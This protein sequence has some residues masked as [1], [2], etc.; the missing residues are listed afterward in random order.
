[1]RQQQESLSSVADGQSQSLQLTTSD[2]TED[3]EDSDAAAAALRDEL[4]EQRD[5]VD[6]VSEVSDTRSTAADTESAA[7][8]AASAALSPASDV[9]VSSAT[10]SQQSRSS[11]SKSNCDSTFVSEAQQEISLAASENVLSASMDRLPTAAA[12]CDLVVPLPSKAFDSSSSSSALTVVNAAATAELVQN[13][14]VADGTELVTHGTELVAHGTELAARGTEPIPVTQTACDT[15]LVVHG[16]QVVN[17]T[18]T[19]CGTEPVAYG[20]QVADG[21][22]AVFSSTGPVSTTQTSRGTEP[23]AHGTVPVPPTR[24]TRG[25]ELNACGT[26][27]DQ[28]K[29]SRGTEPV[30]RG[31]VPFQTTQTARSRTS[32][33]STSKVAAAMQPLAKKG[34]THLL[35]SSS[36]LF[37]R[38]RHMC[39]TDANNVKGHAVGGGGSTVSLSTPSESSTVGLTDAATSEPHNIDSNIVPVVC[40]DVTFLMV[41]DDLCQK[42]AADLA[43]V[44][45]TEDLSS[46]CPTSKTS[47]SPSTEVLA[48]NDK[49]ATDTLSVGSRQVQYI[50]TH[51]LRCSVSKGD[52]R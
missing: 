39:N 23:V 3:R 12:S 31:T 34:L 2:G 30:A 19:S 44:D 29:T 46:S 41:K 6:D 45:K 38:K 25:T 52:V 17:T 37:H 43:A 4:V 40:D 9:S 35:T 51:C 24:T 28:T 42:P 26:E 13:T 14:Q 7:L 50:Y 11:P 16:T 20:T 33:S 18:E 8:P 48:V 21:T 32:S 47:L 10:T 1:V 49:I 27:P 5:D 22:V 36:A 15:E